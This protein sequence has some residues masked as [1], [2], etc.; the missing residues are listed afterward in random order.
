MNAVIRPSDR[1]WFRSAAGLRFG[2]EIAAARRY[3][4]RGDARARSV[5]QHR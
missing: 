5:G 1:S 3:L 4:A 2:V